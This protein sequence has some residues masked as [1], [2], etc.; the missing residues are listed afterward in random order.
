[1]KFKKIRLLE[2]GFNPG[3]WNMALDEVLLNNCIDG[4]EPILRLYGWS[5]PCVSVGYFQSIEEEVN[6]DRC[7]QLGVD[8][9]RR[10]TGGGA[11]LHEFELTYSFITRKFPFNILD[12]YKW[13]CAPVTVCI[14]KLGFKAKY[15]PLND[16]I[17]DNKKISGNAQT[18][19][20]KTLLQHGTILLNVNFEK[21]FSVLKVPPEKLKDKMIVDAKS[22]VNGLNRTFE[23]VASQLK[24]SFSE[25][26]SAQFIEDEIT[27]IEKEDCKKKVAQKYSSHQWNHRR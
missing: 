25:K 18:R 17:V 11:V 6:L 27:E 16:I 10:M 20:N 8:V 13:I 12:S 3:P 22:R 5:P 14:N 23:E 19:K 21:M 2:T 15:V 7:S 24:A 9:V 26:F 4:S 1:L